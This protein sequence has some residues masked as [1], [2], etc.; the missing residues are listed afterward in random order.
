MKKTYIAPAFSSVLP[1]LKNGIAA[2]AD[3]I[4]IGSGQ[5]GSGKIGG[6]NGENGEFNPDA[7]ERYDVDKVEFGSLW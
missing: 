5:G 2:D 6:G 4:N 1:Y 7:K 3:N